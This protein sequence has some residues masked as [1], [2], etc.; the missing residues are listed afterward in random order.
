MVYQQEKLENLIQDEFLDVAE[1]RTIETDGREII[2]QGE[3]NTNEGYEW[4]LITIHAN[5][6]WL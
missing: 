1:T 2:Y 3:R 4:C 6:F 5:L